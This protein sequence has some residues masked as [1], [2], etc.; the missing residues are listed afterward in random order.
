MK[1][2]NKNFLPQFAQGKFC[3]LLGK[4]ADQLVLFEIC[5]N[6]TEDSISNVLLLGVE[7]ITLRLEGASPMGSIGITV[8][9]N[10]LD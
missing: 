9:L 4:D 1:K 3:E 8:I 10:D 7:L 6:D 5:N 2:T